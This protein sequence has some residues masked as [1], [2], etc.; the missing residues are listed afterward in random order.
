MHQ[1]FGFRRGLAVSAIASG[2]LAV[3]SATDA[4]AQNLATCTF[5]THVT[6]SAGAFSSD[7]PG[8]ARC[9]GVI[10]GVL[11]GPSGSF[12]A[13]GSYSDSS[14]SSGSWRGSFDAE[15]PHELSFFESQDTQVLGSLEIAQMGTALLVSGS[16]TVDGKPVSYGGTGSFTADSG[17]ACSGTLTENIVIRDSG[18]AP[19]TTAPSNSVHHR[20]RHH[21]G[22]HNRRHR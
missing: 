16:G 18:G 11:S 9:T 22:R 13:Q 3:L 10:D 21:R 6:R 19:Q 4:Q 8:D 5:E 14:C 7:G 15:I 1:P 20:S 17:H 12:A 2:V